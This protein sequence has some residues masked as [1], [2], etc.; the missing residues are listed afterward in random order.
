MSRWT[1]FAA[2][3]VLAVV[4]LDVCTPTC[5][6][7]ALNSSQS[8]GQFQAHHTSGTSGHC[9]IEEDCFNCAHFVPRA[10]LLV[11]QVAVVAFTEPDLFVFSLDGI[12]LNPYHPPKA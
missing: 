6:A 8:Q 5:E 10:S 1:K 4:V 9:E 2:L 3:L 12:P 7:E 11:K